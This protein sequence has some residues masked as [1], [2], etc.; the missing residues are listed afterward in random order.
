VRLFPQAVARFSTVI[1]L[2][3]VPMLSRTTAKKSLLEEEKLVF[4]IQIHEI[5][6]KQV[7]R[8]LEKDPI[9]VILERGKRIL[10][11]KEKDPKVFANKDSTIKIDETFNLDATMHHDKGQYLEKVGKLTVRRKKNFLM[12][13]DIGSVQLPLHLYITESLPVTKQLV[14]EKCPYPGSHITITVD[15]NQSHEVRQ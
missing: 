12:H 8:T 6:L 15:C 1:P 9:S 7:E 14:L 10:Y 13:Q 3:A 5:F 11:S 2:V 4:Y